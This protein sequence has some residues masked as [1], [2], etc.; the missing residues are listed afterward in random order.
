MLK[1][2][3][4]DLYTYTS[5]VFF[6]IE[7]RFFLCKLALFL[8][9]PYKLNFREKAFTLVPVLIHIH[10]WM[11][12]STSP[13]STFYL[14][15]TRGRSGRLYV[16]GF[17]ES[18]REHFQKGFSCLL[19]GFCYVVLGTL[20]KHWGPIREIWIDIKYVLLCFWGIHCIILYDFF[21]NP[22][23]SL[24]CSSSNNLLFAA[25]VIK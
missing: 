5:R 13:I 9:I 14:W 23:P 25:F 19:L 8:V 4:K 15:E 22:S 1:W 2:Q 7:M 24:F 10:V 12:M 3:R 16:L 6:P 20:K 11:C 21:R 18:L 17:S